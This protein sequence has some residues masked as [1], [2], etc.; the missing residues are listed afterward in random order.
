MDMKNLLQKLDGVAA[1]P[2]VDANSMKK[3]LRVVNEAELNQPDPKYVEYAQLMAKYDMLAKEMAP[4][5]S[6]LGV[7]KGASPDAIASIDAIKTKAE[8]L[9]GP[10]LQAWEQARQKENTASMAQA[11]ANLPAMAAQLE[12]A[13]AAQQSPEQIAYNQLRAQ[14]DST[15]ALRG[16]ANTYADVSPEVTASTNAMRSKL[17]QMAAALKAKGIDAEA[18]YD[19]PDP[20]V[21]AVDL[22]TKY[23]DEG[24]GM[25]RLLSIVTD[26]DATRVVQEN[27]LS[28]FLSIVNKNNVGILNEGT[29]P[30]KVSLP[31]Q[32]AMQH[33]Q[34]PKE[35]TKLTHKPVGR[36]TTIGKYFHKVEDELAKQKAHNRQLI[37][38]YAS[39]IAERVLMKESKQEEKAERIAKQ[40]ALKS[41]DDEHKVY[42]NSPKPHNIKLKEKKIKENEISGHSMGFKPGPGSPG[43]IQELSTDTLAS[44]KKKAGADAK[45]AD[46]EGDYARGDKRFKGINKATNKQFDNDLK[47]HDQ[48]PIKEANAKKRS[49]KNSNPCW[50]GY[51]PVGTKKKSGRTVP[52]CVPKE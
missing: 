3:F 28:K 51:H 48:N 2:A 32:M 1:K 34:Q 26:S 50:T 14:L 24:A 12:N 46:S 20:A 47:K 18:E 41:I 38:Q 43:T 40:Q 37:N 23:V 25:S 35:K 42:K 16:G 19:A 7:E 9:A 6:G 52:N 15:D 44:Y 33:Y 8:Q 30:H 5:A 17:A 13:P 29:N 27:S 4:D 49:L 10:N 31:V 39:T 36:E 22:A 11:N 45:K 21:P